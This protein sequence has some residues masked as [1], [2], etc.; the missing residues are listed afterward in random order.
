MCPPLPPHFE[1]VAA[2]KNFSSY[3]R[4]IRDGRVDR[5]SAE[6]EHKA[7]RDTLE[8]LNA[9]ITK[10]EQI[11]ENTKA[12]FDSVAADRDYTEEESRKL[13]QIIGPFQREIECFKARKE[14]LQ[15]TELLLRKAIEESVIAL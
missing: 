4:K 5:A 7:L 11:I 14:R 2:E 9:S 1:K 10:K 15:R 3:L 13:A 12:T 8:L 6:R